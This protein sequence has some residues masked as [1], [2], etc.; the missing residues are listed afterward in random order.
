[1]CLTSWRA[2]GI[3]PRGT[4]S[5]QGM[6]FPLPLAVKLLSLS[7][8]SPVFL[9][10]LVVLS[11]EETIRVLKGCVSLFPLNSRF[12]GCRSL[13]CG[14]AGGGSIC[15]AP[16]VVVAESRGKDRVMREAKG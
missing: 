4:G 2:Q 7:S 6:F 16:G 12:S 10:G 13:P 1:M 9:G 5:F 11:K 8:P 14:N 3:P 15:G